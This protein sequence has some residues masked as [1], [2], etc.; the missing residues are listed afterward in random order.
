[1]NPKTNKNISEIL[2][3]TKSPS[4]YLSSN[5]KTYND[6]D[7]NFE[8]I[9][10][11]ASDADAE[12][13]KLSQKKAELTQMIFELERKITKENF[14]LDYLNDILREKESNKNN[15]L[16]KINSTNYFIENEFISKNLCNLEIGPNNTNVLITLKND[17]NING[18]KQNDE[19]ICNK[20]YKNN[21]EN[22]IFNEI[23][24]KEYN[25]GN[26]EL[27]KLFAAFNIV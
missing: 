1:M 4:S 7:E 15:L 21:H 3:E 25:N 14:E 10:K 26:S 2:K 13:F 18:V 20:I 19:Y 27:I 5:A 8:A 9:L 12:Y 22:L 24:D 6:V 23:V 17:L 11:Q 16:Q